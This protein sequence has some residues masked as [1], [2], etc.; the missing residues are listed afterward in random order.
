MLRLQ[1]LDERRFVAIHWLIASID[2]SPASI[3]AVNNIEPPTYT[4]YRGM[5]LEIPGVTPTPIPTAEV[6][7]HVVKAGD[8]L[9]SIAVQYGVTL[10]AIMQANQITNPDLIRQG[11]EIIIPQ[12]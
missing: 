1:R 2:A 3:A 7:I 8:T 10:Q 11:Q 9:Y 5:K 12:Q 6:T 4:I